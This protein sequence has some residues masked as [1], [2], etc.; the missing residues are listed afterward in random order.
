MNCKVLPRNIKEVIVKKY[1]EWYSKF[2][3]P[4]FGVD[5]IYA[6]KDFMMSEDKSRHFGE[7]KDYINRIDN[8]RG[9]DFRKTFPELAALI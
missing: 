1:D 7:F 2:D 9:T 5:Q 8:I 4:W 3:N 6:V